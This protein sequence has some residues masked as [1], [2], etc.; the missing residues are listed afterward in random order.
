MNILGTSF[1][2]YEMVNAFFTDCKKTIYELISNETRIRLIGNH[3]KQ[4]M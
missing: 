4:P 1:F 2:A 3:S